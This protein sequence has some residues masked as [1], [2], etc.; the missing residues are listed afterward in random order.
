MLDLQEMDIL[1]YFDMILAFSLH[2]AYLPESHTIIV[3]GLAT[4]QQR[5]ELGAPSW[6]VSCKKNIQTQ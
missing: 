3:L 1:T 5:I 4:V 6:E 2:L